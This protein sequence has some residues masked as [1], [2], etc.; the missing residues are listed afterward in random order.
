MWRR[1]SM[2]SGEK[3]MMGS[4]SWAVTGSGGGAELVGW[5]W[6][7]LNIVFLSE[8]TEVVTTNQDNEL[9]IRCTGRARFG[10][11]GYSVGRSYLARANLRAR[12]RRSAP[13]PRLWA[14]ARSSRG[15]AWSRK[16]KA[17]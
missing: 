1:L 14:I 4:P 10:N 11:R 15:M 5:V 2:A 7:R 3:A 8:T 17:V 6:F 12:T 9:V 13:W 16:A